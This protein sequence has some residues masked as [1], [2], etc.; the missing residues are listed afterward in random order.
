V[1]REGD[2]EGGAANRSR[3]SDAAR[4]MSL[5]DLI[6][7][8]QQRG[9]DGETEGLSR[10]EVDHELERGWLFDWQ[11]A[12]ASALQD[13]VHECGGTSKEFARIRPV[14]EQTSDLRE[15]FER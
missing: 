7:P 12:R 6:C 8:R 2:S 3:V 9:R 11:V 13:L 10:L 4:P 5:D 14:C 1:Q 15:L